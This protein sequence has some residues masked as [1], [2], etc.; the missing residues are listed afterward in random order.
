MLDYANFNNKLNSWKRKP[1]FWI[2]LLFIWPLF[3][4]WWLG[5]WSINDIKK[6]RSHAPWY[7]I[8]GTYGLIFIA[9][10]LLIEASPNHSSSNSNQTSSEI[11]SSSTSENSEASQSKSISIAA[12]TSFRAEVA[13]IEAASSSQA[14]ARS[15]AEKSSSESAAL[16]SSISA[17]S[18]SNSESIVQS[19]RIA[20]SQAQAS[21]EAAQQAN[22]DTSTVT[23]QTPDSN[24]INSTGRYKWAIQ[25]GFTWETR[26]GHST[27]IAPGGA[28]PVGYHWQVQ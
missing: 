23:T 1:I 22:T 14:K 12:E 4:L 28:L 8:K 21:S 27:R 24:N 25:D 18:A 13:S 26:K 16:S 9:L 10:F 5:L 20:A 2:I 11:S 7:K 6:K 3:L 19:S 15:D 17:S